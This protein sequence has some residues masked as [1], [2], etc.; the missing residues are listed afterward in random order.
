[1]FTSYAPNSFR[2]QQYHEKVRGCLPAS[3][4][5]AQSNP[6]STSNVISLSIRG[7]RDRFSL[8]LAIGLPCLMCLDQA[9]HSGDFAHIREWRDNGSD[10]LILCGDYFSVAIRY[11]EIESVQLS[12]VD[13]DNN[14]LIVVTAHNRLGVPILTLF[15]A[16]SSTDKLVWNDI[17]GNPC[18]HHE[19]VEL[20]LDIS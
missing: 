7:L 15:G 17:M 11:D 9:G 14:Q 4:I 10:S 18:Q 6:L 1:M 13:R 16:S 8:L 19:T 3:A 12:S 2:S 5:T 20:S